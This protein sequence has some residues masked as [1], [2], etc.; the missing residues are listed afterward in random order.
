MQ[1]AK[2]LDDVQYNAQKLV[3]LKKKIIHLQ[4]WL[5]YLFQQVGEILSL[6]ERHEICVVDDVFLSSIDTT[7]STMNEDYFAT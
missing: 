6:D 2:L 7:G 3:D 4:I 5:Q 1:C